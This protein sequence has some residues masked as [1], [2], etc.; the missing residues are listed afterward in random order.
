MSRLVRAIQRL[1]TLDE[2]LLLVDV[3]ER[4]ITHRLAVYL[5][6]EFPDWH[7]D[8]EY[9]R[10]GHDP[11]RL[12]LAVEHDVSTEDEQGRTVF[13]D[14][15]VHRRETNSNLLVIEAKKSTSAKRGIDDRDKLQAYLTQLGYHYGAFVVFGTGHNAESTTIEFLPRTA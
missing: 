4:T 10:D 12:N 6:H 2:G 1:E 9:N 5:E 15:I 11:K 13:P 7:V 3:N 8:C 14:V